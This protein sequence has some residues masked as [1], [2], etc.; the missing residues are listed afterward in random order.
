[1]NDT[2]TA[3]ATPNINSAISII[4]IS[5]PKTYEI[6]CSLTKKNIS[7][8]G[9]TFSKEFV[10]EN[11]QIIDEVIILKYVSP[12][13]FTGED[14]IEINCHGGILLTNK[15]LELII[16]NGARLAENG[17]FT[18]RAFL[19]NKLTLRQA[20]SINNLIFAKTNSSLNLAS[21]GIINT[22]NDFFLEIKEILF[23]LIGKIEV[24]IDYP[25]YEDLEIVTIDSFKKEI[26]NI[27][28]KISEVITNYKKISYLYN[29]INVAII[30]EPNSG[31]SSLLNAILNKDKAI[32]SN[33]KGTTRDLVNESVNVDGILLNFIDTAGIRKAKNEIEK[34]GIK[35]T[36]ETI[37]ESDFIIF[38]VDSSKPINNQEKE[39][40]KFIS[41][42]NYV[43]VKNKSDL[44]IDANPN[45]T[46]IKISALNK[47]ISELIVKL[48][49]FF[50]KEDFNLA[51]NLSI[52]S[53]N[54]LQIVKDILVI[55]KKSYENALNNFPLDLLVEDLTL[56]YKKIC[57]IMGLEKD[58]NIIDKMFKNFCLG[59]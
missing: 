57:N 18:K 44:G 13:S 5:G 48:K 24:N 8:K 46:G 25:E 16:E 35:K 36:L 45:L 30:G 4:R 7:K 28:E 20:N 32:V 42:K 59:K 3:I 47:D 22:N 1:M 49:L 53:D 10:Y 40:L 52:C 54:E 29:G 38:L 6:I 33:I 37:N 55:L 14:L 2:I 9:Y 39:I 34:I 41:N 15:I 19:N 58:L 43:I 17:E 11:N 56:A 26:K 51:N 23:F 31:K 21:S 27:I 50:K 12:K